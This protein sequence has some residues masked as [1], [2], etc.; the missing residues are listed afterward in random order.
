M[1]HLLH[2]PCSH[3]GQP[4]VS[5]GL[6]VRHGEETNYSFIAVPSSISITVVTGVSPMASYHGQKDLHLQSVTFMASP[7]CDRSKWPQKSWWRASL[8]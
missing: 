8:V 7:S 3:R 2:H 5:E 1:I 4:D 6:Q